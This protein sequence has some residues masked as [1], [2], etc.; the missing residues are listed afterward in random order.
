MNKLRR[1]GFLYPFHGAEE[2]YS[3]MASLV[4]PAVKAVV[5]TTSILEDVH[6]PDALRAMGAIERIV[7]GAGPLNS[8]RVAAAMWA[9]TSGS[10]VFGRQGAE[11]Q[12]CALEAELGL[13]V[14]STSLAF[15]EA[16]AALRLERVAVAA[17]YPEEVTALFVHFLQ[18]SGLDVV[19]ARHAGILSA[20]KVAKLSRHEVV[21]LA[22]AADDPRAEAVLIPDTA[23]HAA[24]FVPELEA[25]CRKPVLSANQVTFWE[26]LRLAGEPRSHDGLGSLFSAEMDAEAAKAPARDGEGL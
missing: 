17:T 26:A 14:S 23:L 2:E 15:V 7:T 20:V 9:C 13:P 12:A 5:V 24:T 21:E 3:W 18:Q 1:I 11:Q 10:F 22:R 8:E 19:S 25:A 4:Q 6:R 16:A